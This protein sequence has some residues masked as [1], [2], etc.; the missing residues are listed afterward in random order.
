MKTIQLPE[1]LM[2]ET[3]GHSSKGNQPKWLYRNKYYKADHMGYEGL[4]EV[5]ISRLLGKTNIE[6]Y[7]RY[8]PVKIEWDKYRRNGCYSKSF[9]QPKEEL[10]PL[11]KLY[12]KYH[13]VS[14]AKALREIPEV[15][16]RI[17][18]TVLFVEQRTGLKGFGAYLGAM[19]EIDAFFLNEDRH[20]NNIAVIHNYETGEFRFCPYFD[21]GLSLLSDLQGFWMDGDT[22][23]HMLRATAK[24]FGTFQQ[25]RDAVIELYGPQLDI[26]FDLIDVDQALDELEEY[27]RPEYL[28][29]AR[30]VIEKQLDKYQ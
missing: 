28:R 11:E 17:E 2:I 26:A 19:I 16:D 18:K 3:T 25:Q 23:K 13:G 12:R 15:R 1:D 14:L 30:Y 7:V 20:T 27:Y 5:L 4:S 24:P 8:E 10:I 29:R 21:H 22:D 6:N 9:L